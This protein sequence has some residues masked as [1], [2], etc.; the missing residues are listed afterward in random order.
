MRAKICFRRTFST[1]I[2]PPTWLSATAHVS[3][4]AEYSKLHAQSLADPAGFWG[5]IASTFVWRK[6]WDRV[7][8]ADFPKGNIKW[9]TGGELNVRVCE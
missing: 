1:A 9:F 7:L 3:S 2:P 8:D 4:L 6:Q 5:P